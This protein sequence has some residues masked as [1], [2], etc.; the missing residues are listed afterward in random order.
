MIFNPPYLP[1]SPD[2]PD[3]IDIIEKCGICGG[4]YPIAEL[5]EAYRSHTKWWCDGCIDADQEWAQQEALYEVM[6]F[7]ILHNEIITL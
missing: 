6:Q 2:Y 1:Y 7:A 5:T 3:E 4:E